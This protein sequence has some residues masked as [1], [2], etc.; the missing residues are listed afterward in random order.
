M[1]CRY[2][3][4]GKYMLPDLQTFFLYILFCMILDQLYDHRAPQSIILA[5]LLVFPLPDPILWRA[6]T[7]SLPYDTFPKTTCLPSNHGQG[8]NVIKNWDPLVLGPALAI[9]RRYGYVC[10]ILKFSSGTWLHKL[11]CHQCHYDWWNLPLEPWNQE[12]PC[13]R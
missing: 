6:S 13:G 3:W 10:L 4:K 11:I 12:W 2:N 1:K 9:E 5:S 8:T 7:T